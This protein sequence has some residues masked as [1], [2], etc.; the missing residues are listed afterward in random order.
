MAGSALGGVLTMNRTSIIEQA[1][2]RL[3]ELKRSGVAVPPA[4]GLAPRVPAAVLGD[5]DVATQIAANRVIARQ[6]RDESPNSAVAI[7]GLAARANA[8]KASAEHA[9]AQRHTTTQ[10]RRSAEVEIDLQRLAAMGYLVSGETHNT[11]ASEFRLIKRP[12]LR[13]V[14]FQSKD[15]GNRSSLIMI[16]SAVAGEGKTFCAINLA[17]SIAM[18]VDTSVLL[19]DADVVRPAVLERLGISARAGLLDLLSGDKTDVSEVMLRTNVPKLS[20]LPAG[21]PR[22]MATELLA[23]AAMEKLLVDLATHYPDRVVVM[24]APPLLL[25]TESPVLASRAGQ[26]VV[27]VDSIR[28]STQRVAQAFATVE[29]CPIVLSLLN[30]CREPAASD[31][32]GYAFPAGQ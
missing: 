29:S 20:I 6:R 19:V 9:P 10:P 11:V 1:A 23:S 18:E 31:G 12:L 32:Y 22:P 26:V 28:T 30:K 7:S 13:N 16:T 14:D 3:E 15:P 25:T 17:M 24:D 4:P 5:G 21:A 8:N 2:K 27:V